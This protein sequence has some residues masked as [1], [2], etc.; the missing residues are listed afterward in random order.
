MYVYTP[1]LF[2][3]LSTA[4]SE[5][6]PKL[7]QGKGTDKVLRNLAWKV[8]D[9][10]RLNEGSRKMHTESQ[11]ISELAEG[12]EEGFLARNAPRRL[13]LLRKKM[14]EF[15]QGL[16]RFRRQA[17]THV[18][19]LM[20]SPEQRDSKPY[21]IPV[22]CIPYVSLKHSMCRNLVNSLITE[23]HRRGMKIAGIFIS[24]LK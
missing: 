12:A 24:T 6:T 23:M 15:L 7:A 20:I 21:A 13:S 17:A 18:F 9:L 19:V 10:S 1:H 22:Q 3:E 14:L 11:Q 4:N 8:D 5:Y 16:Y 2:S